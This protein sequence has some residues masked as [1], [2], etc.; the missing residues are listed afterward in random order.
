MVLDI[1]KYG[2]AVLR[3]TARPVPS[4]TPALVQLAE[5]MV[6][7][8]H[9]ARGVGLAAPQ[10]GRL[11]AM[12]VIDV[13][14]D[15]EEDDETRAFNAAVA[16]PLVMFNPVIVATE[17]SQDG[18]EGCLSLP[19]MSAPVVR[20]AQVTCQ[21]TDA[22]GMPQIVTARGF[23]A[24]ALLHETDHLSG[25]LYVDHL[26]AVDKLAMAKKLQKLAKKNGG[27]L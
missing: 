18:K 13:P 6:D 23:L 2:A 15:C 5:D 16:M 9:K 22:H 26:S 20:A 12:C 24:R 14:A 3:E 11:E 4:V 21:Y 19:N 8:M 10:V 27:N 7:T 1:V 17:G 25:I